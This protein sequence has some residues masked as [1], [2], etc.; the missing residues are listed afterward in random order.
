MEAFGSRKVSLN[1]RRSVPRIPACMR[2]T[3]EFKCPNILGDAMCGGNIGG[4]WLV[5][6]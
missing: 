5:S 2:N 4:V 6:V 3:G 1:E